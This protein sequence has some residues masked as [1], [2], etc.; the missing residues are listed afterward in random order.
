MNESY[1]ENKNELVRN[2]ILKLILII[3]FILLIVWIIP[4][5]MNTVNSDSTT[6]KEQIF[7]ENLKTIKD[8]A[9]G[10][11]TTERLPKSVGSSVTLTLQ[12]M[13]DKKLVTEI[14]DKNNKACAV[15]DSYVTLTKEDNE[16]VMKVNL[17]CE[18]EEDYILV[19]LGCYSYCIS[20]ICQKE[21]DFISCAEEIINNAV[22]GDN[23]IIT[24]NNKTKQPKDK[25]TKTTTT[26]TTKK[27]TTKVTYKTIISTIKKTITNIKTDVTDDNNTDPDQ[28]IVP[29]KPS[30]EYLYEYSKKTITKTYKWNPWSNWQTY[31][32]KDNIKDIT[33]AANDFNCVKEVQTKKEF[34]QVGTYTQYYK[35]ERQET[36]KLSS[37][38]AKYCKSYNYVVYENT[39]Y[40]TTGSASGYNSTASGSWQ[41]SGSPV[42]YK[43]PPADTATVRYVLTGAD[44]NDCSDTCVT[45]PKFYYQKYVYKNSLKKAG[46]YKSSTNYKL[47]VTC[48]DVATKTIPV[49]SNVTVYDVVERKEPAYAYVKYYRTRTRTKT[50][51]TKEDIKWSYYNDRSL[52][53]NGYSYTGRKKQK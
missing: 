49:Y 28:P 44:Y 15:N 17:S 8:A 7:N 16:Y 42:A 9:T 6:G 50:E 47:T 27:A 14:K 53:N 37:Y 22:R 46:T 41:K 38:K 45:T 35:K 29:D 26:K 5:T 43:N 4:K 21:T 34:E 18:K 2:F 3:L 19:H 33:C 51:E 31:L 25:I 32:D 48:A 36:Q 39:I 10:Y 11:F 20:D 23:T 52:L 12:E 13:Y 1:D 24:K 40:I 30:K